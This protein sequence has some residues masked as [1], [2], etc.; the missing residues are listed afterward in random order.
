MNP[1]EGKVI[2][3]RVTEKRVNHNITLLSQ[4]ICDE[5]DSNNPNIE[6][7][8]FYLDMM[9]FWM[10]TLQNSEYNSDPLFCLDIDAGYDEDE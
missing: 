6:R 1:H 4:E 5:I 9:E 2:H 3:I 7:V 10:D 8:R